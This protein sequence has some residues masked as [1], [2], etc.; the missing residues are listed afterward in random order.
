MQDGE[1]GPETPSVAAAAS[2]PEPALS[3]DSVA[4][5]R[6]IVDVV[7]NGVRYRVALSGQKTGFYA[8][9]RGS[10]A[11]LREVVAPGSDVMDL[12]CYSG[13]FAVNAGLAGAASVLGAR[14]TTPGRGYMSLFVGNGPARC[15][16]ELFGCKILYRACARRTLQLFGLD[17]PQSPAHDACLMKALIKRT[18]CA[19]A[20]TRRRPP[21]AWR[22]PMP[23]STA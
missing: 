6:D 3:T 19:Q 13:G 9:Q 1:P 4:A 16:R 21:W 12:C 20:S 17:G 22:A 15:V 8:D 23:S 7:E 10:R 11:F 18:V 14:G 2:D 5:D